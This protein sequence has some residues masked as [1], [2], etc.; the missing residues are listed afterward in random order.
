MNM[1]NNETLA[2]RSGFILP[3]VMNSDFTAEELAEDMD[4]LRLS[5][6]QVK[7]PAGGALQFEVPS[8]DPDNPDYTKTLEGVILYN[9][10]SYAYWPENDDGDPDENATPLCQSVDG[11]VGYGTPG[12]ICASC[13]YNR[14][15]SRGRGKACKNSRVLYLLQSGEYMPIQIS[16][17]PTSLKPFNDFANFAFL[18]RQRGL[19]SSVVQIGLKRESNGKDDYSVAT[20]KVLYDFEGEELAKIRAFS[21]QFREQAKAMLSQRAAQ[22]EAGAGDVEMAAAPRNMPENGE[23]FAVGRVIDGEREPLP[24]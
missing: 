2:T 10:F 16:L 24:A 12:G 22:N 13:G 17:P 6:K 19:C 4:G 1:Q 11:K 21:D 8:N 15:G 5:F 23:Q 3:Q 20:F 14:F 18:I 9:H 7:I